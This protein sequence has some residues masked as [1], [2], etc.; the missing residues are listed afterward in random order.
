MG[1]LNSGNTL[2]YVLISSAC[3]VCNSHK[4]VAPVAQVVT[5]KSSDTLGPEFKSR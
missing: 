1:K 2:R 5:S 4:P 3:G